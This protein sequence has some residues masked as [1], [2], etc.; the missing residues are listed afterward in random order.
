MNNSEHIR[1][2]CSGHCAWY[3]LNPTVASWPF[4]SKHLHPRSALMNTFRL[5]F[6]TDATV[7]SH[8]HTKQI[9][10]V[11]FE[12]GN[13]PPTLKREHWSNEMFKTRCSEKHMEL[14]REEATTGWRKLVRTVKIVL[15]DKCYNDQT[16]EMRWIEKR[17]AYKVLVGKPTRKWPL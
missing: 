9:S 15:T 6:S 11:V 13:W 12:C 5:W 10:P 4:N 1:S 14:K 7:Q 3:C 2:T 17:N 8:N 16:K